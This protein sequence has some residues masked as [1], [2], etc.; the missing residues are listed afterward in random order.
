MVNDLGD[1]YEGLVAKE[2]S[3]FREAIE[4]VLAYFETLLAAAKQQGPAAPTVDAG[5]ARSGEKDLSEAPSPRTASDETRRLARLR[6]FDT[7]LLKHS[8]EYVARF[9]PPRCP[10]SRVGMNPSLC[11]RVRM[12]PVRASSLRRSGE[13]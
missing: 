9:G 5:G 13:Q 2:K 7:E 11:I 4:E 6:Q 12:A 1:M 10:W 8:P 3:A